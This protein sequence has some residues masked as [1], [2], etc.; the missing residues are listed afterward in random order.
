EQL[1]KTLGAAAG[2]GGSWSE[3]LGVVRRFLI[4]D[5]AIDSLAFVLHDGSGLSARNLLTPQATVDLLG[6]AATRP[7]AETYRRALPAPGDT[8]GTLANRLA[9][10]DGRLRAKTG[11]ISNVNSL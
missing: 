6:H 5:V 7:W 9:P 10:L 11:T 2:D 4:D 1:V 3:G 8:A